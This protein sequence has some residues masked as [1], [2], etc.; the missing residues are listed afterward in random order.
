MTSPHERLQEIRLM[1]ENLQVTSRLCFDH[2]YNPMY[3][4]GNALIPLFTQDY[5]GYKFPEEKEVVLG[6]INQGLQ[7]DE[8]VFIDVR[9]SVG[10]LSL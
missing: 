3:W 9:D 2:N 7:L 8:K 5:E 10:I 6:L 1:V 4:S